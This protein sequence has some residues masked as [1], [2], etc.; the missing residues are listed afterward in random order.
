[1]Q[2]RRTILAIYSL[3]LVAE[4]PSSTPASRLGVKSGQRPSKHHE[5]PTYPSFINPP[6][7]LGLQGSSRIP[8]KVPPSGSQHFCSAVGALCGVNHEHCRLQTLQQAEQPANETRAAREWLKIPVLQQLKMSVTSRRLAQIL[9]QA[10]HVRASILSGTT[11]A[12][13]STWAPLLPVNL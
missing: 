10:M 8:H 5:S 7:P 13:D 1:M 12:H 11:Q 3:V 4:W 9:H 6:P 2:P